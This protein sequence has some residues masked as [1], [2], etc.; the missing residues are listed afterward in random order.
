MKPKRKDP[1]AAVKRR[2]PGP[3]KIDKAWR[4]YLEVRDK[5]GGIICDIFHG[6]Q[7][8]PTRTHA[9]ALARAIVKL[10]GK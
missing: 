6:G 9:L 2:H 1:L 3:W 4:Q 5:N 7:L 10:G 8:F